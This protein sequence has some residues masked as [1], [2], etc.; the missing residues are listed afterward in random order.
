MLEMTVTTKIVI[1]AAVVLLL[2]TYLYMRQHARDLANKYKKIQRQKFK[3]KE[4]VIIEEIIAQL[5]G[6]TGQ[7]S[8]GREQRLEPSFAGNNIGIS[9]AQDG[10]APLEPTTISTPLRIKEA[11]HGEK[12]NSSFKNQGPIN[13]TSI[14][15]TIQGGQ[16]LQTQHQNLS[17]T[18]AL[19]QTSKKSK[20]LALQIG[21]KVADVQQQQPLKR[22]LNLSRSLFAHKKKNRVHTILPEK[23]LHNSRSGDHIE[24][25]LFKVF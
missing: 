3:S 4:P 1:G 13:K 2:G 21:K 11:K 10:K 9:H 5:N 17:Q 20:K 19:P 22:M 25:R 18:P 15:Q 16:N 23:L 7:R 12:Q 24:Q 6:A 8:K 14:N